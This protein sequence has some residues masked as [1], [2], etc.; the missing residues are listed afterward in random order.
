MLLGTR[1]W[2]KQSIT[3]YPHT[4]FNSN[5]QSTYGSGSTVSGLMVQRVMNTRDSMGNDAISTTQ[6]LID[7]SVAVTNKDKIT[8]PDGTQPY[9]ISVLDMPSMNNGLSFAKIIYT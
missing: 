7:G 2:L 1:S 8:L 5:G 3:I 4:G 6:I 9:I